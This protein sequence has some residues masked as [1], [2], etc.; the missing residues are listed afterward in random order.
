M[1]FRLGLKDGG[2]AIKEVARK[3]LKGEDEGKPEQRKKVTVSA[4]ALSCLPDGNVPGLLL[5]WGLI[6]GPGVL[7]TVSGKDA[8]TKA[9]D[10]FCRDLCELA[11]SKG[12]D[13]VRSRTHMHF[14]LPLKISG[15]TNDTSSCLCTYM[16]IMRLLNVVS[17]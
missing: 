2:K 10:E 4:K 5:K 1:N 15:C 12:V 13:P 7:Q 11:R 17:R 8:T 14:L 3:R 9:L 6:I 16:H